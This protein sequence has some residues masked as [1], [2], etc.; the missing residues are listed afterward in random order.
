[1]CSQTLIESDPVII[2]PATQEAPKS[3]FPVWQ[4]GSSPDGFVTLGCVTRDLATADGLSYVWKDASGTALTTN[5]VQYPAVIDSGKYSSVSQARVSAADWD[6]NKKFTCEVTNSLGT[7]TAPLQKPEVT[8]TPPNIGIS[9]SIDTT[10]NNINLIC[11]LD[12]FSPKGINVDWGAGKRA[13]ENKF[14]NEGKKEFAVPSQISINAQQWKEGKEFT[15]NATHRTKTYSQT[16]SICKGHIISEPRI[17][18]EKPP[19]RSILTDTHVTASCVVETVFQPRISWLVD[20]NQKSDTYIKRERQGESTVSNLTISAEDWTKSNTITC[21]A[22][23]PCFQTI[24][25]KIKTTETVQKPPAVVIRRSVADVGKRDSAVLECVASGLPSG[26][27]SVTFQANDE[28]F[29]EAHYVNLPKGQDTLIAPF[30]IPGTHRT[31]SY[32][33][34]CAP[35][36][37]RSVVPSEDKSASTAQKLLCYGTGLDPVIKWLPE[38]V[39]N[40]VSEESMTKDGRVKVSSEL[41]VPEQEWNRGSTFTCQVSDQG[42]R[43]TVEKNISFCAVTPDH[44]RNAQV[45]LLGPTISNMPEEDPVSVTCLLLGHRLQDFSVNCK[46]GTDNLSSNVIK[47]EY[48]G[49]GTESVQRVLRVPAGK[50]KNH[51][52]VSCEVKH[53]CSNAQTYT[54]SKTKDLAATLLLTSPTQTELDSGTA[55][56]ICLA[57]DFFPES[58]TF[59]WTHGMTNLDKKVKRTIL[60]KENDTFTAMSILELTANE[61]IGSSSP[62]KCEFQHTA[63]NLSKEASYVSVDQQRPKVTIIPPSNEDILINRTGDLMCKAEGP[64][65]FTGIK[66]L[67][68]GK[69]VVSL[70]KVGVSGMTAITLTTSISYEEWTGLVAPNSPVRCIIPHSLRGLLKKTTEDNM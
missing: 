63:Q 24:E 2:K 30:T 41:S 36:A 65:G 46:V 54:T 13:T 5:V 1:C 53:P 67:V 20:G 69:E 62:V 3:L 4:C 61:W 51:E 44:A 52:K 28:K 16:W 34:T 27:L 32:R 7:K 21:R 12:G 49:N 22:E 18:L 29:P 8:E 35:L 31:K 58:H 9:T 33:F 10:T 70:P 66:W 14:Q 57:S 25:D 56:F 50:W 47:T 40:S 38:S 6:A 68:N 43:K 48:H 42:G 23:H 45:Y 59:K 15:C 26:D 17:R 64:E 60:S 37:E 55:T 39:G 19:L 11:W